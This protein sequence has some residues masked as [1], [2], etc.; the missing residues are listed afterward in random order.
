MILKRIISAIITLFVVAAAFYIASFYA[1]RCECPECPVCEECK[2]G[3]TEITK[4]DEEDYYGTAIITGYPELMER[5]EAWCDEDCDTYIYVGFNILETDDEYLF[6]LLTENSGN[7]F[8]GDKS[9]G[10]GCAFDGIIKYENDSDEFGMMEY[11]VPA[12][13]SADIL[14]ATEKNPITIEV[15]KYKYTGGRGAP[16]CYSHI[17]Q[18]RLP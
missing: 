11:E 16:T 9:I 1:P 8:I 3:P 13:L 4:Y 6:G 5:Q 18:I 15:E 2:D 14:N 12:E 10:L 17:S 7:A